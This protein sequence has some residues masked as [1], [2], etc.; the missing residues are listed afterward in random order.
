MNEC[1]VQTKSHSLMR[2]THYFSSSYLLLPKSFG[3][4]RTEEWLG[5]CKNLNIPYMIYG[6]GKPAGHHP[7][8]T[9]W[10]MVSDKWMPSMYL[11]CSAFR[12]CE[13]FE[14]LLISHAD[15]ICEQTNIVL[16]MIPLGNKQF[17]LVLSSSQV[18]SLKSTLR[19]RGKQLLCK[20][21]FSWYNMGQAKQKT[22]INWILR[23]LYGCNCHSEPWISNFLVCHT[24]LYCYHLLAVK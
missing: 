3:T 1:V 9:Y 12:T 11:H 2:L 16:L 22:E 5:F 20:P 18:A 7:S 23:L 4:P 14:K 17:L 13:K 8:M 24:Q 19:F 10:L 6:P 15:D 21:I